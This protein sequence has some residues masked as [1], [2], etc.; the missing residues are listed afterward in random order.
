MQ[1]AQSFFLIASI[2]RNNDGEIKDT[3]QI[4]LIPPIKCWRVD[5]FRREIV[6]LFIIDKF[7]IFDF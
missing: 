4:L 1:T 3:L 6:I 5:K 7:V 2:L